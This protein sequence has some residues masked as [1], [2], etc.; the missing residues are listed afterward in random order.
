MELF[1]ANAPHL[2]LELKS[3]G[4]DVPGMEQVAHIIENVREGLFCLCPCGPPSDFSWKLRSGLDLE[5]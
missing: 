5:S 2:E 3:Q 4:F 1:F